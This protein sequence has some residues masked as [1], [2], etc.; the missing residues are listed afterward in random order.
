MKEITLIRKAPVNAE[1]LVVKLENEET[2]ETEQ[3]VYY[4]KR[5]GGK[6]AMKVQMLSG[7]FARDKNREEIVGSSLIKEILELTTKENE[8]TPDLLDLFDLIGNDNLKDLVQA[9]AEAAQ[10]SSV[11]STDNEPTNPGQ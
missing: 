10:G 1:R 5:L 6:A 7:E 9:M 4:V 2:G 11:G 3:Y 8:K